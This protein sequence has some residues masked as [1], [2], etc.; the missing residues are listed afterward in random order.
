MNREKELVKNTAIIAIGK[1][2]TQFISFF[3]L[4]LYTACLTTVEY[5]EVDLNNTIRSLLIPIVTLMIEQAVYVYMMETRGN[6]ERNSEIV[7]LGIMMTTLQCGIFTVVFWLL[8][9]VISVP[10]KLYLYLNIVAAAY[11]GLL[12]QITRGLRDT[13]A[14]SI[15]GVI[16]SFVTIVLNV[17]CIVYLDWGAR[18]MLIATFI[19]NVACILFVFIYKKLWGYF[20]WARINWMLVKK[21]LKYSFPL[22][23][24][25]LSIWLI[26]ASDRLIV[27]FVLG[28]HFTGILAVVHKF[29]QVFS[30]AFNIFHI[31]WTETVILHIDDKDNSWFLSDMISKIVCFFASI[32]IGINCIVSI[33]FSWLIDASYAEAYNQIPINILAILCN[34]MV[35]LLGAIYVAKKATVEVAKTT[36]IS[37]LINIITHLMLIKFIGLYAASI[38]TLLGY[39]IM[40]VYRYID[41]QKYVRIRVYKLTILQIISL[42]G[43]S[44][45]CYYSKL[46]EI[47]LIGTVILAGVLL[48]LNKEMLGAIYSSIVKKDKIDK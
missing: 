35:G 14:Y 34:V 5:G 44:C 48:L 43:F 22:I 7:T 37:G 38:S 31:S 45:I 47:R 24:N 39:A 41:V 12:L 20:N 33:S 1:V 28:N 40:M 19:G 11:S 8:S 3:L 10:Y 32:A 15:G 27:S 16:T 21:F 30:T 4:P 36:I 42:Y 2:S 26:S 9:P 6:V 17:V 18:G 46:M 23:P 13:S 29:P 25:Q